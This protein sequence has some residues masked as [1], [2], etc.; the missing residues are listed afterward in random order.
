M[1]QQVSLK[2]GVAKEKHAAIQRHSLLAGASSR[3]GKE[4]VS[5]YYDT[6][7]LDLRRAGVILRLRRTDGAA[8]VQTLQRQSEP[9]FGLTVRP[10]WNRPYLNH[11]DFSQVD[12]AAL[13]TWLQKERFARRLVSVFETH[14]RR[15]SWLLEPRHGVRLLA[16]LDKGWIASNG[17]REPISEL[18]LELVTGS[19]EDVYDAALQIGRNV[20]LPP[21]LLS[22]SERGYRLHRGTPARP[23]RARG[24]DL[25]GISSPSAAFRKIALDCL[26]HLQL[27][28]AGA[29]IGSDPEYVHQMRVAT[30]RLRAALRMFRPILRAEFEEELAQPLREL[31]RRLGEARD[32]DVLVGEIVT[33]VSRAIPGDPRL[34]DLSNAIGTR[35][36]AA[37]ES[38]RRNLQQ[39]GY[40]QLLLS[41][42]RHLQ[43]PPFVAAPGEDGGETDLL[44]FADR[45]LRRLLKRV[46]AL[47]ESARID[48]PPSLHELRIAIKRLRYAIEFFGP[49]MPAKTGSAVIKRLAEL[50]DDL[51]QL[52][53]LA[54][55]GTLLMVCAGTDPQLR[56]AVT[57]VGGWHGPRHAE[58]LAA[59]PER[60]DSAR[61]V[62]LPRL[63]SADES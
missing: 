53:D 3:E 51:G 25:R 60:I 39:A 44:Q 48:H 43:L 38:I 9:G 17:Q 47:A 2:L 28:H 27:N 6:G 33:P 30:R 11:F 61:Q 5:V 32:L 23:A 12:D 19:V 1:S 46:H 42:E 54:N 22:K 40:G 58:L 20:A 63:K 62:K 55:A 24:P 10:E 57:L 16:K 29:V 41:A 34:T 15:T 14:F 31:M 4:I 50:Q 18:E 52:N 56:E 59:I 26:A 13:R 45:R 7:R 8:W 37:R 36:I 21:F 35:Q 49:L